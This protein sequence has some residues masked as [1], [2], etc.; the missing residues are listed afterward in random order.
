MADTE[1]GV[2]SI[3]QAV[4]QLDARAP[5]Q[6][7]PTEQP[8]QPEPAQEQESVS[9]E[10]ETGETEESAPTETAEESAKAAAAAITRQPPPRWNAEEREAFAKMPAEV[11][12]V[13]L[14]QEGKREAAVQKQK[15]EATKQAAEFQKRAALLDQMLPAAIQTFSDKWAN[16]NWATLPDQVG[17]EQAFK[18]KAQYE[19]ER[20][21]LAKLSAEHQKA[22]EEDFRKF[23]AT[24]AEKLKTVA[25]DL[26]DEKQGPARKQELGKFLLGLGFPADRIQYMSADEASI[27]YDAMRWREAQAKAKT[28]AQAPKPSAQPAK[29]TVKPTAAAPAQNSTTTK[30]AN[31]MNRLKSS[32]RIDDAVAFLD[33]RTSN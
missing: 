2:L 19:A 5:E 16:V 31:A 21:Q 3:D 18:L 17:G 10:T 15:E 33:A 4:A 28:L 32:G 7:Q 25:P 8:A 23:V 12:D 27:A 26:V 20:D 14:A 11:Q 13:L 9:T 22:Q 29:P 24:E 6:E 30:A 1:T